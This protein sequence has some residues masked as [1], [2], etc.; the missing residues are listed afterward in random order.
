ME[1]TIMKKTYINPEIAVIKIASKAQMLAG[2]EIL[3]TGSTP[4]DPASSDS[5][6]FDFDDFDLGDEEDF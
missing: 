3:T 2:S 1:D 6:S 5:R 4:T